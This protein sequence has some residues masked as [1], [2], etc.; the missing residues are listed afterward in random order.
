MGTSSGPWLGM[1]T[2]SPGSWHF[3][4]EGRGCLGGG[5]A[6]ASTRESVLQVWALRRQRNPHASLQK[7]KKGN[8]FFRIWLSQTTTAP[9]GLETCGSRYCFLLRQRAD[10]AATCDHH[11]RVTPQ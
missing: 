7:K 8:G 10:Q 4:M 1:D 9:S 5:S 11:L 6:A 3:P 2:E